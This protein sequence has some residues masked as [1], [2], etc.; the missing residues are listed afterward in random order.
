M[1]T[2]CFL[3]GGVPISHGKRR[4]MIH[5]VVAVAGRG[6]ACVIQHKVPLGVLQTAFLEQERTQKTQPAATQV[7]SVVRT[8][9][10][11]PSG[12]DGLR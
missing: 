10:S 2:L 1:Y 7:R 9:K 5:L 8:D 6:F 3:Q 12:S 11:Y 4:R